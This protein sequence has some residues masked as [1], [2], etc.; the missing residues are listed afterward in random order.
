MLIREFVNNFDLHDSVVER[1]FFEQNQLKIEIQFSNWRQKKFVEGE[2]EI[3]HMLL[4]FNDVLKF[5]ITPNKVIVDNEILEI[6]LFTSEGFDDNKLEIILN[7]EN[8]ILL[9]KIEASEVDVCLK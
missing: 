1:L 8:D 9:L 3:I 5:E 7:N 2:K 4:I 6:K